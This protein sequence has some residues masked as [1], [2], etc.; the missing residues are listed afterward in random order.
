MDYDG[1]NFLLYNPPYNKDAISDLA[2]GSWNKKV[3]CFVLPGYI[4]YART[5]IELFGGYKTVGEIQS[6]GLQ[7]TDMAESALT[8]P[9]PGL[10]DLP[11]I[12]DG[13][14]LRIYE[15]M[16]YPYQREADDW[17]LF[18]PKQTGL[19]A[20]SPGLGKTIVALVAARLLG[21][22][23]VLIVAPKPL[24]RSWENEAM[25]FFGKVWFERRHGLPPVIGWN[26]TNYDTVVDKVIIDKRGKVIGLGPRLQ[27]YMA[28]DWDLVIL[29]E[30]V[31]VKNRDSQR[32]KGMLALRK[33][34]P[35]KGK[36]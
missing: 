24:L 21:L 32:Y 2:G 6:G 27:Q 36:R 22:K 20:L 16:F 7:L 5:V 28:V 35:K 14:A 25:K 3:E 8:A 34:F 13:D 1:K 23:N 17:L 4:I 9:V 30:S 26:L 15:E 29:D 31:L 33:S 12:H 19:V 11:T 18:G 10:R